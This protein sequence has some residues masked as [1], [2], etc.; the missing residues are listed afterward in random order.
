MF[1][2]P[3][4]QIWICEIKFLEMKTETDS[5]EFYWNAMYVEI[6]FSAKTCSIVYAYKIKPLK[7]LSASLGNRLDLPNGEIDE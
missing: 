2:L 4:V 7:I 1:V 5:L 3:T 6:R